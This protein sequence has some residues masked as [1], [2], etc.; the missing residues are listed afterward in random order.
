MMVL[1]KLMSCRPTR[2]LN[3]CLLGRTDFGVGEF[4]IPADGIRRADGRILEAGTG[5][6]HLRREPQPATRMQIDLE[7]EAVQHV[8]I[9]DANFEA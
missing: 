4:Q 9:I 1:L 8:G 6:L 7:A 5:V 3:Q 2:R